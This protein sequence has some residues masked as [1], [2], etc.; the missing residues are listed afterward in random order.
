[1]GAAWANSKGSSGSDNSSR[2]D[3]HWPG[4]TKSRLSNLTET[5]GVVQLGGRSQSSSESLG[6]HQS[7]DFSA[8]LSHRLVG[9]LSSGPGGH[10]R[11]MPSHQE[12]RSSGGSSKNGSKHSEGLH[13]AEL[14]EF[15]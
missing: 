5:L 9:D 12:L 8:S 15:S 14:F 1:M 4:S 11:S 7:S 2:A 13:F 3:S 6:L 10:V